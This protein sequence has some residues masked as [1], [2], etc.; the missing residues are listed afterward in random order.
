MG[1]AILFQKSY[2][3]PN[4][5]P[6]LPPAIRRKHWQVWNSL[7][8][9][10]EKRPKSWNVW[11]IFNNRLFRK[12]DDSFRA[13][14]QA[15]SNTSFYMDHKAIQYSACSVHFATENVHPFPVKSKQLKHQ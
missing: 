3:V 15:E 14:R 6:T 5:R 7:V 12:S 8:H 11:R 1:A 9:Q 4:G 2:V 10:T 13:K